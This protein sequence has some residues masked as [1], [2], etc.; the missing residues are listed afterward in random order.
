MD[1]SWM[2]LVRTDSQFPFEDKMASLN[3]FGQNG[4]E[5]VCVDGGDYIFKKRSVYDDSDF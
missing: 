1:E 3:F 2:Y 4:W 5:L